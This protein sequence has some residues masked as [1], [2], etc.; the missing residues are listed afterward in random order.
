MKLIALTACMVLLT[1]C[2]HASGTDKDGNRWS[3]TS[4]LKRGELAG[5]KAGF[6]G[7]QVRKSNTSGDAELLKAAAE[8]TA[9]GAVQGAL[10][11]AGK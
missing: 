3:V 7:L 9:E 6:D 5:A 1:G 4:L 10:K 8:G 11:A 2:F